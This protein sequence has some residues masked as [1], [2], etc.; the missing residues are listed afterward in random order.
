MVGEII[1]GA[2]GA[3]ADT[4]NLYFPNKNLALGPVVATRSAVLDQ[5]SFGVISYA[6]KNDSMPAYFDEI[7]FG[8]N[9]ASVAPANTDPLT[10]A[11]AGFVDNKS[12][13][14]VLESDTLVYTVSFNKVVN[15]AT[16]DAADFENGGTSPITF[17]N[18]TVSGTKAYVT[19]TPTFP[20]AAGTLQLGVKAG[21]VIRDYL[22]NALDTSSPISDDTLITV[23]A[24]TVPPQ[25]V[26][27]NSPPAATPIY[28][29][30][31]I[32]FTVT[33]NKY[34]MNDAT[35]TNADF[36]NLGTASITVGTVTRISSGTNPAV[37]SF[38][39]TPTSTGTLRLRLSG[40][41][42]D[43]MGNSVT[44]PVN[45]DTILSFVSPVSR[46]TIVVDGS[47]TSNATTGDSHPHLQCQR[48]GQAR[49]DPHR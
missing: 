3:A 4:I 28:G 47:V 36:T 2:D 11:P 41:V 5:S 12:G 10:L 37:Y 32:P 21:A 38:N 22:G 27:I 43:A 31:T 34:F 8:A 46:G 29:L 35:V 33:F 1:W 39:V 6:H 24:D 14:P 49:G 17:N 26:S 40:T 30:P 7:R 13:G 15:P 25:V 20:G 18:V 23:N 45:D 44:V 42:A 19:V 9:Y 48:V 16:I